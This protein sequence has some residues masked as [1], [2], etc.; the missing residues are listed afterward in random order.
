LDNYPNKLKSAAP[1][2]LN[3]SPEK[4]IRLLLDNAAAI[5]NERKSRSWS[6][7]TVDVMPEIKSWILSA[8]PNDDEVFDRRK[9]LAA[10]L[11][12]WFA[13]NKNPIVAVHAAALVLSIKHE[14]TSTPPGEPMTV[15]WHYGVVAQN[16]LS[17]I[18]TLWPKIL[19]ILH[20]ALPMQGSEIANMFHEWVHPNCPGAGMSP[21]YQHESRAHARRM[22]GYLLE[23]YA[24]KWTFHHH[25]YNYSSKLGLLDKI[26]INLIAKVLY[27]PRDFS[28]W[29]KEQARR[30]AA[31]DRLASQ[32]MGRDPIS[33]AKTLTPIEME[34]R[35]ANISV[36]S[37]GRH[38]CWR[39]AEA[40]DNPALWIQAFLKNGA[41]AD[42]LEPFF[43]KAAAK[44]LSDAQVGTL[45]GSE[46]RDLQ[47]LGVSLVVKHYVPGTPI[48]QQASPLFKDYRGVIGVCALR[49]EIGN[50][51]LKA[52][53]NHEEANV[54]AVVAANMW[55]IGD[56]ARIPDNLFEDWK[57]EIIRHVDQGE[58]HILERIF[59][60]YPDIAF[61]W[62]VWRLEGTHTNARAFYFGLRHDRTLPTAIRALTR[63]QRRA[64][65]D[66][67]PQTSGVGDLVCYLVD[68]DVELFLH[69]LSREEL[70]DVRLDPLR[71][72]NGDEP[73]RRPDIQEFD[74]AWQKMAIAA[75]EKGFS[76]IDIV[77]ATQRGGFGWSG[78]M[79]SMFAAKLAPFEKLL[80]HPNT[81]LQNV[82]K[83]ASEHFSKLRDKHLAAEKR[84]AVRGELA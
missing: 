77:S 33:V 42:L 71:I 70:D 17:K 64:L 82:G 11:E 16:Q 5:Y 79:S 84:A 24:G 32:L 54:S 10:S 65:I 76:E 31:A 81:K 74:D 48:W 40:T 83:I 4:T 50:E 55:G 23:A 30:A 44:Q 73:Q 35:A 66:K 20:E 51:N 1:A 7:Q 8:K 15:T 27:P 72:N 59:P 45:L 14:A 41:P 53:L 9:L 47:M 63:E 25:L 52:L 13:T 60:K 58:E 34:A 78:P 36:P 57:R 46:K 56:D 69:L 12:K 19:P 68:R 61:E 3:T 38:V 6:V 80:S 39:I 62:I 21:E 22:I 26:K 37:W 75:M 28:D 29:E 43:K 2:A 18:A 49:K 67:L